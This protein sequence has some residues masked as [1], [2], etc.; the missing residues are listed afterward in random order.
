M[1]VETVTIKQIENI[2]LFNLGNLPASGKDH[3]LAAVD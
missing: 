2:I 3:L 1:Y